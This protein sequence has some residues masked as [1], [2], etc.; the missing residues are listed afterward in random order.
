M[1]ELRVLRKA[2]T[3]RWSL[4]PTLMCSGVL[5]H[6]VLWCALQPSA[7]SL[8]DA[9]H[10]VVREFILPTLTAL[11]PATSADAIGCQCR[12]STAACQVCR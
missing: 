12:H 5:Y 10:S 11:L 8:S 2:T 1:S 3:R 9:A 6:Y 7:N 4:W